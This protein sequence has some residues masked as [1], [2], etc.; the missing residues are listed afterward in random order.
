MIASPTELRISKEFTDTPGPRKRSEGEFS[1]EQ[2]LEELLRPRFIA[3][4]EAGVTLHIDLDGAVG[5]PSSF[6]E[7]A[8]G[9]LSR[10]FGYE[11][12][13]RVLEFKCDD[14]PYLLEQIVKYIDRAN[15]IK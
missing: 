8:F 6:L 12:V 14:E 10:E 2:F 1:G 9:G 15:L 11:L 13:K 7:E 3:A 5:Y 4:R